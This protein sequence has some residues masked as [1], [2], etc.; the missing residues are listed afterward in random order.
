ME[1][2]KIREIIGLMEVTPVPRTPAAIRGVI[3]LRGKIIPVIDLRLKFEMDT[4]AD[5]RQT[6]IIVVDLAGDNETLQTGILVDS[7]SEVRDIK[8]EQIESPPAFGGTMST[9]FVLGM[10]KINDSVKILLNIDRVLTA[11]EIQHVSDSASTSGVNPES[12]PIESVEA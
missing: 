9:E 12:D 5:T 11:E 8:Q 3:N 7:V 10:A 2:L 1:I 4:V 6:C